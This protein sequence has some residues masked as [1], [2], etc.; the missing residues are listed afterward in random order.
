M[1]TQKNMESLERDNSILKLVGK[2]IDNL[3]LIKKIVD[4][5]T[6]RIEKLEEKN[7]E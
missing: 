1:D 2:N 3:K 5:L 6:T 7:N 4:N